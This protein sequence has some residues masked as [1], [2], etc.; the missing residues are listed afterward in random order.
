LGVTLLAAIPRL[1]LGATQY[2][3]YDG[4]WHVFIAQQ[5]QWSNFV[6]EYQQNAHPPL[7]FLL[8]KLTLWFGRSFLVYRAISLVTGIAAVYL[9]GCIARKMTRWP[10]TPALAG[11]AYGLS[12]PGIIISC[13]VRAYMLCTFLI[14][15]SYYFF[16]DVIGRERQAGSFR[17]R[18]VFA[19][20]AMLAC[21]T[22]YYAFFYV[23]AVLILAAAFAISRRGEPLWRSF[24][25]EA[26]TF[27]PV[28]G[29]M[30]YLFFSHANAH[31][32]V[33][34]HLLPF[35]YRRAVP[36]SMGE[37]LIRNLQNTFNLFAPWTVSAR[38][39]FLVVLAGLLPA[40]GAT[41]YLVRRTG[42]PEKLPALVTMLATGLMLME[43]MAAS[44]LGKYPFGG[45]LR[46][47]FLVFPF[48]VLCAF[49]LPDRLATR[50]P[51]RAAHAL[52]GGLALVTIVAS[53][54]SFYAHPKT[55]SALLASQMARF[56]RL[57]PASTAVYV[58][59]FSL[60]FF[61]LH[62]DDW[63]WTF[64]GQAPDTGIYRLSHDNRQ[65]LVLRDGQRWILDCGDAAL[66][67][68]LAACMRSN[69][70]SSI[71]VFR[72]GE[73][74]RRPRSAG[75]V[76][77]L[78]KKIAELSAAQ[79]LCVQKL[80][81]RS[82]DVY[83][84]FRTSACTE[85]RAAPEQDVDDVNP[86]ISYTGSWESGDFSGAAHG[87]LTY[88]NQPGETARLSFRGT[89]IRYVYTKAYNRGKARVSVDGRECA[90][91][92]LYDRRIVWQ[93]FTECGG[94]PPGDHTLE[95]RVL[96]SRNPASK[97]T[98]VDIDALIPR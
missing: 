28:L 8:L 87:T 13:E 83:A 68:D 74:V 26:A 6:R 32:V 56:E 20:A 66:Y 50:L 90:V 45:Y 15:I 49:L 76:E 57:F 44:V 84:E 5:D 27:A 29:V 17:Q 67:R 25:R 69:G 75:D 22:H 36:E 3:E 7:Y 85:E 73:G 12:L 64:A 54:L 92:D 91:V 65:M 61:F 81:I 80:D 79:G 40:V 78:R 33:Q 63:K 38:P 10:L 24:G 11:L 19:S 14:L 96:G 42:A 9:L 52:A 51:D 97:D 46:Q 72:L 98:V 35:Y 95:I 41:V 21:L 34:G 71:R 31:A 16:L 37:F 39:V 58:D 70:L 77:A 23:G 2:I 59:Q 48:L 30:A 18:A 82:D 93:S 55:G 62:H 60:I 89:G 1:Y 53:A 4:Y 86:Y 94:L 47:Q 43:L 88:T